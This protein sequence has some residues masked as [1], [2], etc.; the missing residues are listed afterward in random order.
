MYNELI[1]ALRYCSSTEKPCEY[2]YI[3]KEC[4]GITGSAIAIAADAIEKLVEEIGEKDRI[5]KAVQENSGINFR[6]WQG[7]EAAKDDL[8]RAFILSGR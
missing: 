6:M 7:A 5:L 4:G 3:F 8:I 1:D 2:C